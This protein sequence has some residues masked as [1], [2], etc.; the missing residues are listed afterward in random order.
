MV[1]EF[2]IIA[3]T[4]II[5]FVASLVFERTRISQVIILMLFGFLLGPVLGLLDVSEE[6]II[7]SV[8]PFIS[9][10]ALIVLLFDGGLELNIF[11]VAKA[12]PKSMLYTLLVFVISVL[13]IA[14][15]I[16]L[17]L[18]WPI[19]HSLLIGAVVG[20]TSSAVVIAMVERTGAKK[21]TKNMLTLESTMTDAL[22]IITAVII[23]QL[24]TAETEIDAGLIANLLLSQFTIAI[25]LGLLG[26]FI[27]IFIIDRIT[28]VQEY[29]YMLM[30]SL[31][32]GLYAVTE[33]VR[34][35]GG[36]AVFVFGIII[37]NARK[38]AKF[39]KME[40][41]NPITRTTRLFQEEVTFFVRTFFF[42]Y[43]GLLLS[44]DYFS[45]HVLGITVAI[46]VLVLIARTLVQKLLIPSIPLR[47]TG[48]IVT[49]MPRGL[50]VAVLATLPVAKGIFIEN[51]QEIA[52]SVLLFSN[53]AATLG[54][55]LFDREG[56]E[57]YSHPLAELKGKS[58]GKS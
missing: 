11:S 54:I 8:L 6:S 58:Q 14:G 7:V 31:V 37:G 40:W 4:I 23:I 3:L 43:I 28:I 45:A 29:T 27:W 36:I 39:A 38:I 49:M 55:F 21:N 10:L 41:E 51:F 26:A 44:V 30:L 53:V 13:A 5:G 32:F 2:F 56:I 52:F 35:N 22:C 17:Y 16:F 24:M 57:K 25:T 42:T 34:G 48:V 33:F 46:L 19:T 15:F 47:D 20:G 9:T 18:G 12:I 50:A 1:A